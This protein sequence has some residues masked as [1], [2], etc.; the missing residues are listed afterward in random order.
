MDCTYRLWLVHI[1]QSFLAWTACSALGLNITVN[2]C[3]AFPP[4]IA[5]SLHK[6]VKGRWGWPACITFVLHTMVSWRWSIPIAFGLHQIVSWLRMLAAS[7]VRNLNKL[8]RRHQT[9]SDNII[10]TLDMS[11]DVKR[12][13]PTLFIA[14]RLVYK[15]RISPANTSIA[16]TPLPRVVGQRHA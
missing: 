10:R 5:F 8:S 3:Q 11:S 15:S 16:W 9:W 13:L 7:M 2:R 4:C 12:G 6:R 1:I 14:C